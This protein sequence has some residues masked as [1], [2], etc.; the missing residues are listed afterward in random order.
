[1]LFLTTTATH[2][3]RVI[4]AGQAGQGDAGDDIERAALLAMLDAEANEED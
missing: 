2:P 4:A 3:G 1:M